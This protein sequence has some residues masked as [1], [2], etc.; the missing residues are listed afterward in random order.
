MQPNLRGCGSISKI[1]TFHRS[2]AEHAP[3][4]DVPSF[5]YDRA[6]QVSQHGTHGCIHAHMSYVLCHCPF[7]A[8]VCTFSASSPDIP[9]ITL[10]S[11]IL[12]RHRLVGLCGRSIESILVSFLTSSRD[13]RHN[14]HTM[15]WSERLKTVRGFFERRL[16]C[17]S[18]AVA[19]FF[20]DSIH[21][22]ILRG[23]ET[24]CR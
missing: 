22:P 13:S 16:A 8:M 17:W 1:E 4:L 2:E 12:P 23:C 11:A 19:L 6:Y 18:P 5:L 10:Y 24:I 14:R 9:K 15:Y 3:Y 7:W 20:L 21:R